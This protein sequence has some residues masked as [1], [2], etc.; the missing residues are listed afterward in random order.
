MA[1]LELKDFIDIGSGQDIDAVEYQFSKDENFIKIID[2]AKLE[3]KRE[4]ISLW[5]SPLPKLEEDIKPDDK[6]MFYKDLPILYGRLKIFSGDYES[7]WF[8]A[9]PKSQL[10]QEIKI[11]Y[12]DGTVEETTTVDLGWVKGYS[13]E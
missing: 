13:N 7:E 6:N 8:Y 3:G 11:T 12:V 10:E 2:S 4:D 9:E 1:K 5:T